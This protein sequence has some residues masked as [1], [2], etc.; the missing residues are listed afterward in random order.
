MNVA[1][2]PVRG[3][4]KSIPLKNIKPLCGKPLVY[5]TIAAA[6]GCEYI[7]KVYVATDSE[8]IAETVNLIKQSEENILFNKIEV[9]GRS[10][11]SASDTASTESAMIEFAVKYDFQNI[12]LVQATSPL[13]L[14]EDLNRGFELFQKE[15][16]DSVLS[17]VPQKRF[18]WE[19]EHEGYARALN[20]DIFHRPRRQEFKGYYVE[21]GAFYITSKS[22][23]LESQ[24]RISGRI[25]V[26]EMSE[27]SFFEIDE[28]SDWVIIEDLLKERICKQRVKGQKKIR[29]FLTDCDG[30]LTDGGMYYTE[31]GDEIKK[32][33]TQDGMG[34]ELLKQRGIICGIITGENTNLVRKR[35]EKLELNILKMGVKDKIAVMKQLCKEYKISFEEV[36]YVGDDINDLELLSQVGFSASVPNAVEKVKNKVDFVS[37]RSG[38]NGAV[39]EIIDYILDNLE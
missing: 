9:I 33:H 32:F 4:S 19:V 11:E 10:S 34:F 20:Y 7:D 24:N 18:N 3:G 2:I 5:W 37:K 29:M 22:R 17:A 8:K 39:R 13:L 16:I 28:P 35:A 27:N 36:A 25:A 15:D 30:C 31:Y 21:N 26:C 14:T 12:V 23:L 1:F 38:G 6:C